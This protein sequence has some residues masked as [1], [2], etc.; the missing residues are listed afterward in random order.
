VII[1]ETDRLIVRNWKP[2]DA[3]LFYLINSDETVMEFF[4]FRRDRAQSDDMMRYLTERIAR[5]GYGF[6]AVERKSDG[7]PVGFTALA[8][9]DLE[10]HL[11]DGTVEVGWRLAPQFWGSGYAT[12]AAR[13]MLEL[14]FEQRDLPEIVSFAV[15]E[16]RRS[17]AVMERIGLRRDPSRDFDHPRVPD[18]LPHLKRHVLYAMRAEEWDSGNRQQA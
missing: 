13:A 17:T 6:F 11:P 5:T 10:P 16:N 14:G 9:T 1:A 15:P 18:T 3:D 8:R 7:E 12:E 4:P 2:A